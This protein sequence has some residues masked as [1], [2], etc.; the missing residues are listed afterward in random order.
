M[1]TSPYNKYKCLNCQ[2]FK[3]YENC[4]VINKLASFLCML[5][6]WRYLGFSFHFFASFY[7]NNATTQKLLQK[8]QVKKDKYGTFID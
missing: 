6:F 5:I 1:T 7:Y 2:E 3:N 4:D 8:F